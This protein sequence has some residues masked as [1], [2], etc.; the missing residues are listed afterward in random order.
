MD[1]PLTFCEFISERVWEKLGIYENICIKL[2]VNDSKA[3]KV[4]VGI[5]K[6]W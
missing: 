3:N 4:L 6:G 2:A 1:K 5:G